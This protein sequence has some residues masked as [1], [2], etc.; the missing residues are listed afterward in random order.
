MN[1][2]QCCYHGNAFVKNGSLVKND[3][4][5]Q[6]WLQLKLLPF[7]NESPFHFEIFND[8]LWLIASSTI[9]TCVT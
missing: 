1:N 3:K 2:N 8:H 4:N 7:S 5:Q 9:A 6:T